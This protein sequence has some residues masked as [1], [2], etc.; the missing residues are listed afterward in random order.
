L[1]QVSDITQNVTPRHKVVAG[2]SL[3]QGNWV[4]MGG[5]RYRSGYR[6]ALLWPLAADPANALGAR[7]VPA[8]WRLDV[9]AQWA[10]SRQWTLSAWLQDATDRGRANAL[11]NANV[12]HGVELVRLEDVGRSLKLRAHY[13]L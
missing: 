12:L 9:G 10:P 11:V 6:E 8:H 5:W 13:R 2:A 1:A 4:L 3:E 7:Q